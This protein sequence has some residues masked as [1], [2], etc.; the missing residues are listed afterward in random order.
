MGKINSRR[1]GHGFERELVKLLKPI[2][3]KA[4]RQLEYQ[5]S[6]GVDLEHTG[7]FD[8]QCKRSKNSIPISKIE[9]IPEVKG[10]IPVLVSKQDRKEAYATL[11]LDKFIYL[12]K[13]ALASAD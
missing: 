7:F 6:K 2:F 11:P 9:E 1:K 13:K 3:P 10:R 4:Q 5:E 12:A 8:F